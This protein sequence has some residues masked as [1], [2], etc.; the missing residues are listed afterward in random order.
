[1]TEQ[2][3]K[4]AE[5]FGPGFISAASANDP[6]TVATLAV[7]GATT[8]YALAWLVVLLFPM[9]VTV[10]TIAATIGAVCRTSVQG[11]IR[12]R[13]GLLWASVA[14]VSI[15]AVN[16][17]TLTAD[18]EAA[19][20]S[21]TLVTG[22][23]YQYFV[24]PFVALVGWLI[25]ANRYARVERVLSFLPFI[26]LAYGAS[27]L[28]AH[29][30][31]NAVTRA[32][33][34]PQMHLNIVF[35]GGGLALLGTTLTAYVYIW[36][37]I[38]VAER[39][40]RLSGLRSV[41]IDATLGMLVATVTFLFI[42]VATGATLGKHGISVNTASDAALALRPLAG[43]WAS[44][45]FG[46]GL[47]GSAALA[48]PVLVGT[49]GYVIAQT[50]G[51]NGTL[52][53]RFQDARAFYV[54]MLVSLAIAA[55]LAFVGVSPIALLYWASVAGGIATPVTLYFVVRLAR[56]EAVMGEH[57]IGPWLASAGWVVMAIMT[58]AAVLY[59]LFLAL[60]SPHSRAFLLPH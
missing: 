31:W 5:A 2:K 6:T 19:S 56:D 29:A 1:M 18:V 4:S 28:L 23:A 41:K 13:Y 11:A 34:I 14:L 16:L 59:L 49:N 51:L 9:L 55:A 60:G 33:L 52:N 22:V 36:E 7:V 42:L 45:L 27:A 57:R 54:T 46:I 38:E 53:A 47:L 3:S 35:I 20:V 26:F 8:G 21:L 43:T 50:F 37:S 30:D 17:F 15:I 10:Q 25:V 12:S 48:V 32:I 44:S 40:P 58:L 39:A 24:L